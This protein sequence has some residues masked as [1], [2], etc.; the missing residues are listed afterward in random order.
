MVCNFIFTASF[1]FYFIKKLLHKHFGY[2]KL[3]LL[4]LGEGL[5]LPLSQDVK[6]YL[7]KFTIKFVYGDMKSESSAACRALKW[8]RMKKK[9]TWR[10]PSDKES[11]Q[12]KASRGNY[13]SHLFNNYKNKE[14]IPYPI[15][16]GWCLQM[17]SQCSLPN[18]QFFKILLICLSL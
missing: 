8:S 17:V 3:L 13:Q 10:I 15:G 14:N 7:E 9:S 5:S 6:Q 18:H 12:L 11:D 4:V 2:H 1:V 16:H